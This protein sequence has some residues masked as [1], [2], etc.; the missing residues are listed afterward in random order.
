MRLKRSDKW[1]KH[2]NIFPSATIFCDSIHFSASGESFDRPRLAG[3]ANNSLLCWSEL[4]PKAKTIGLSMNCITP[5]DK[6]QTP[7]FDVERNGSET[8]KACIPFSIARVSALLFA[9]QR[10][11]NGNARPIIDAVE[12]YCWRSKNSAIR[13]TRQTL[14][15][16]R[17][18]LG[19]KSTTVVGN[20]SA[21]TTSSRGVWRL[22]EKMRHTLYGAHR[23]EIPVLKLWWTGTWYLVLRVARDR[24]ATKSWGFDSSNPNLRAVF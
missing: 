8:P 24:R 9:M 13:S 11:R 15:G 2:S 18:L 16:G 1:R 10:T 4:S 20:R 17:W 6:K 21:Q 19:S 3:L 5:T 14:I 12:I 23:A 22:A 7:R